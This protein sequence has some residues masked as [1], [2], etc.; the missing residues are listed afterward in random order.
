MEALLRHKQSTEAEVKKSRE[1]KQDFDSS[2]YYLGRSRR[3]GGALICPELT[4]WGAER[5]SADYAILKEQRKITEERKLVK[6]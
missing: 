4:K 1:S 2:V 6:K 3:T 5:A